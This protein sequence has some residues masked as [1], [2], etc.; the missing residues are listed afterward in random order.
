L[1]ARRQPRNEKE[2]SLESNSEVTS[3]V[4]C[5]PKQLTDFVEFSYTIALANDPSTSEETVIRTN[6]A[7]AYLRDE[8][9][10]AALVDTW[11]VD[12]GPN[13]SEK[14]LY[15]EGKALYGLRRFSKCCDI[16]QILCE[17]YPNNLEAADELARARA[18]L[19][20][21][22]HGVYDFKAIDEE[23]SQARP[24]TWIMQTSLGPWL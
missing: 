22:L 14:R 23:I 10:E 21:Q 5:P 18:R 1:E 17:R 15:R 13:I 20:E 9:Y 8:N 19:P 3:E 24:R 12:T 7:L 16:F 4:P 2:G 11:Y 6:R